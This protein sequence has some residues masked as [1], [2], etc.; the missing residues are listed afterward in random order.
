MLQ[1]LEISSKLFTATIQ[2]ISKQAVSAILTAFCK[3]YALIL[4][5]SSHVN[6]KFSSIP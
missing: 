3:N 2:P 1:I 5:K 6:S 4:M